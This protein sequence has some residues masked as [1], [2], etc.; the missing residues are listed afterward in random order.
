M[1]LN[2]KNKELSF[3]IVVV[4]AGPIGLAFALGFANTNIKVG[5]IDKLPKKNI[6]TPQIDGRE[7]ALTHHSI[8]ILEKLKCQNECLL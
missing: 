2:K 8:K 4:G 3:D 1:R 6:S 7:I 5:I